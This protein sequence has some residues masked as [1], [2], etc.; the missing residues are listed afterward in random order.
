MIYPI[1]IVSLDQATTLDSILYFEGLSEFRTFHTDN[2]GNKF[3]MTLNNEVAENY[4][5]INKWK[6]LTEILTF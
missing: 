5:K 3:I 6:I 4:M 2:N 1:R